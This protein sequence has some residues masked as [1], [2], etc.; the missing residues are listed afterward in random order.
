MVGAS[1]PPVRGGENQGPQTFKE[2]EKE[3]VNGGTKVGVPREIKN[4]DQ[5]DGAPGHPGVIIVTKK[6]TLKENVQR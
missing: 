5:G 1:A 6:D 4:K 3:G 2:E